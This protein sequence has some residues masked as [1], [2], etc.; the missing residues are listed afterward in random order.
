MPLLQKVF[1]RIEVGSRYILGK[2]KGLFSQSRYGIK[3]GYRHRTKLVHWDDT[4]LTDEYQ[5]EVYELARQ[6][7]DKNKY[8]SVLDIGCGSGYKLMHFF[9]DADTTGI[10]VG[11]T[12]KFLQKK[13]P[14]RKWLQASAN[15]VYPSPVDL[16][17]CSDVIEHIPDPE[18]FLQQVAKTDFRLLFLST[19]ERSL[20]RG[21]YDY[22]PP[23]HL[24]HLREWNAKE[25]RQFAALYFE[26][27]SHQITHV[28]DATQLL[29]CRKRSS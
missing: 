1:R 29:I 13:Y 24:F 7:F 10:E 5:K 12:F 9:S 18:Q 22:G 25:F 19:P 28:E 6:Y 26:I 27:V 15:S 16:I 14:D 8:H 3:P 21:W 23:E 4:S 11:S 17:I 20:L 2:T